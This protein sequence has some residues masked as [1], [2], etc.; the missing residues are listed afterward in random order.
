MV[1]PCAV[2][3]FVQQVVPCSESFGVELPHPCGIEWQHKCNQHG[4]RYDVW[5]QRLLEWARCLRHRH[6]PGVCLLYQAHRKREEMETGVHQLYQARVCGCMGMS[7][8]CC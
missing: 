3:Q 4:R 7:L 6:T 8:P 5:F 2:S 1:P